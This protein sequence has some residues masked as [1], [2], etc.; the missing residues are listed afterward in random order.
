MRKILAFA[1]SAVVAL[2][3]GM[4]TPAAQAATLEYKVATGSSGCYI[5]LEQ[6]PRGEGCLQG[7]FA[8][9]HD[10]KADGRSVGVY[11]KHAAT[12]RQGICRLTTGKG[13]AGRCA[14]VPGSATYKVGTCDQTSTI[15]CKAVSHYDWF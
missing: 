9:V 13:T 15:S 7:G 2:A 3:V 4:S 10:Y 8:G 12:G 1:S 6:N 14:N 11:W 5:V